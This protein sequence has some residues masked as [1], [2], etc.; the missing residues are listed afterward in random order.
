MTHIKTRE[1]HSFFN[2]EDLE[3][4]LRSTDERFIPMTSNP[5]VPDC[6]G[7]DYDRI[8]TNIDFFH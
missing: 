8:I 4:I 7:V 6:S 2:Q 3:R 5:F 1:I